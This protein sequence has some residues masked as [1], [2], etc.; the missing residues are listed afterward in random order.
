MWI[1]RGS[2]GEVHSKDQEESTQETSQE[3]QT[4]APSEMLLGT[5]KEEGQKKGVDRTVDERTFHWRKRRMAKRTPEHCE[6]VHTDQEETKEA[7]ESRIEHFTKKGYQ[8]FTEDGLNA[9]IT[10]D[11]VLQAK[12][13]LSDN[14]VNG[15]E[16]AIGSEMIKRLPMEKIYTIVQ[17]FQERFLGLVE[18]PSSWKIVKLVF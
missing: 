13:K 16:D 2:R 4:R 9:E 11:L 17:C 1:T 18:P 3:S 6:E 8:Q 7:Q 14:K 5:R 12:A 10:I 15:P